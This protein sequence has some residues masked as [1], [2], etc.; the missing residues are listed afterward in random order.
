MAVSLVPGEPVDVSG[1]H[2][3]SVDPSERYGSD[4]QE[5]RGYFLKVE[6]N[7]F[8]IYVT[9][10]RYPPRLGLSKPT[11]NDVYW[12]VD[13]IRTTSA[14]LGSYVTAHIVL[15]AGSGSVRGT[16]TLEIRKDLAFL[17]DKA[18]FLSNIQVNLRKGETNDFTMVWTPDEAS[19]FLLRG[20]ILRVLYEGDKIYEMESSY[21][22]RLRVA[23]GTLGKISVNDA[24]WIV[25][26]Q[27]ASSAG[28]GDTVEADVVVKA[29]GGPVSGN[30]VVKVRKDMALA[31]DTDFTQSSFTVSL[32]EGE[33]TRLYFTWNP[34]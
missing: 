1:R 2:I 26:G 16:L 27:R 15:T 31:L 17:P 34:R 6:L 33:V 21:P 32:K 30:V 13:G 10:N 22:P 5:C 25:G 8:P 12:T 9:E 4:L 18:Y 7:E 19:G 29:E 24:Y 3:F 14:E 28:V 23:S 20:Y 11:V